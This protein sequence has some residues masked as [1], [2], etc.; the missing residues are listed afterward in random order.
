[1]A[2][3]MLSKHAILLHFLKNFRRFEPNESMIAEANKDQLSAMTI[4]Y[5]MFKH[6]S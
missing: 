4:S 6:E 2:S 5:P 1:M 3:M